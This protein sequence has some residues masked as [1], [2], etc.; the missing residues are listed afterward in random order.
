M[1]I[2]LSAKRIE[3]KGTPERICERAKKV[4]DVLR[5]H[6]ANLFALK[7]K[8]NNGRWAATQV[9]S[10]ADKRFVH[11]NETLAEP[12]DAASISKCGA[13]C[14][15]DHDSAIFNRVVVVTV[16]VSCTGKFQIHSA[17]L[18]KRIQHVIEKAET[19][20]YSAFP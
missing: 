14:F 19:G 17:M 8:R 1:V 10:A 12:L 7:P 18:R 13:D 11:R 9:D 15:R 6:T 4:R 2:V 5:S 20:I 3:V 16:K